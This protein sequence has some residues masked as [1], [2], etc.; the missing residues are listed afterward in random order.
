MDNILRKA[1]ND[2]LDQLTQFNSYNGTVTSCYFDIQQVKRVCETFI[3]TNK[4]HQTLD[5]LTAKYL[6]CE[7]HFI[8][9]FNFIVEQSWHPK[10]KA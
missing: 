9:E 4:L 7:E 2:E 8:R 10:A 6:T 5:H 1:L 3:A